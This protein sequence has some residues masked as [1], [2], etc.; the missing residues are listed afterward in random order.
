MGKSHEKLSTWKRCAKC[1]RP[2]KAR[3]DDCPAHTE[4]F[5]CY[6]CIPP[7]RREGEESPA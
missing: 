3:F 2:L 4:C 7:K 1:G 5:R 6:M